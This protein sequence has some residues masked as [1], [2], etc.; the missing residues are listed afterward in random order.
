MLWHSPPATASFTF[1]SQGSLFTATAG[2]AVARPQQPDEDAELDPR[3]ID[4]R[5]RRRAKQEDALRP[6]R[7]RLRPALPLSLWAGLCATPPQ[8]DEGTWPVTCATTMEEPCP[9]RGMSTGT[10]HHRIA[11]AASGVVWR[12][13]PPSAAF[14]AAVPLRRRIHTSRRNAALRGK[15]N[16]RAVLGAIPWVG[17]SAKR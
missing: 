12:A 13:C 10:G 14:V 8:R 2:H 16:A 9:A 17:E 6:R 15:R 5:L 11:A 1:W 7:T 3:E 4:G